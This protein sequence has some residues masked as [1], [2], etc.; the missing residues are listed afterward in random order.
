[1]I[2]I[3]INQTN[4][5]NDKKANIISILLDAK[6]KNTLEEKILT[7][8]SE[9]MECYLL[10]ECDIIPKSYD[11]FCKIYWKN[12]NNFIFDQEYIFNVMYYDNEVNDW[13]IWEIESSIENKSKIYEYFIRRINI[14]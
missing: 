8:I 12:Q 2:P 9:F 14:T 4:P 13:I 3:I 11:E 10:Y 5:N 1:M 6:N 7:Y